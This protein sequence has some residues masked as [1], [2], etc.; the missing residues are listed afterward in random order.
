[1]IKEIKNNEEKIKKFYNEI[2]LANKN[3][4]FKLIHTFKFPDQRKDIIREVTY[5]TKSGLKNAIRAAIET[6]LYKMKREIKL[7]IYLTPDKIIE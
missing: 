5:R 3:S 4:V 7:L 6:K 1:M 2:N